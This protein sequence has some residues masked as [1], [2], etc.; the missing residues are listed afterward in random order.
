MENPFDESKILEGMKRA[1]DRL[2]S[3][4]YAKSYMV[5]DNTGRGNII[6]T[7]AGSALKKELQ[8]IFN[9]IAKDKGVDGMAEFIAFLNFMIDF[10]G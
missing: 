3:L 2:V 4:G 6:W 9:L 8:K 5:N 7:P 10:K 1:G